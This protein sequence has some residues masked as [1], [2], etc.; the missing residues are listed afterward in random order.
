MSKFLNK[1]KEK[2]SNIKCLKLKNV[3]DNFHN[4]K[5]ISLTLHN[6]NSSVNDIWITKDMKRLIIRKK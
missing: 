6:N 5:P 3:K 1:N 2:S 4:I